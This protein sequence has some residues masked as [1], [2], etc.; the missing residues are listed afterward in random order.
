MS[1]EEQ[2]AVIGR[3]VMEYGEQKRKLAA[4]QAKAGEYGQILRAVAAQLAEG[5]L[6]LEQAQRMPGSLEVTALY[7]EIR[8]TKD[9]IEA[10]ASTLR[11]V[12]ITL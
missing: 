1:N 6:N 11:D 5:K 12:G 3:A 9:R 8:D 7:G 4:L 2:H 10:L